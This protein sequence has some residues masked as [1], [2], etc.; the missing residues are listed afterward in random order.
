MTNDGGA[1]LGHGVFVS[2]ANA[3]EVVVVSP[4]LDLGWR[5]SVG[6]VPGTAILWRDQPFE[7]VARTAAGGGHR[8]TLRPWLD[9]GAMRDVIPLDSGY[10]ETTAKR[11]AA[12][13]R[14]E[15]NRLGT[16]FLLPFLGLAPARVQERWRSEWLFPA[17]LAT[18]VS[19]ALELLGG[20]FGLVQ[21]LALAFGNEWFLPAP[22]RFLAGVGPLMVV[23][24]IVRLVL[25]SAREEPVGSVVGL[26]LLLF[27]KASP[28]AAPVTEPQVR[29]FDEGNGVLELVSPTN[30][31]DWGREGVLPYRG[32]WFVLDRADSEGRSWTYRFVF[33][34][35]E[36]AGRPVLHLRTPPTSKFVAPRELSKPPSILRT[37]LVTAAV[38]LGPAADQESWAARLDVSPRWLTL[39]GATAELIGGVANLSGDAAEGGVVFVILDVFLIIEGAVRILAALGGRPMGSVFGW[40]LR[41]L[42][43]SSLDA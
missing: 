21:A 36:P 15:Y 34:E 16:M 30:R 5:V 18:W 25:V 22:L 32:H 7:V 26:P 4:R 38:T 8:W 42:Y 41:P 20:G 17:D 6:R 13:R 12:D 1:D 24:A 27:E 2:S 43:R 10:I 39:A 11:S 31:A 23:E 37:T 9:A 29:L 33:C 28:P 35:E 40:I 14:G 19:S 3:G